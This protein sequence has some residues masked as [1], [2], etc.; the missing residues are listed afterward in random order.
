MGLDMYL[1]AKRYMSKHFDKDDVA[2]QA[3]IAEQFPELKGRADRWGDGSPVKEVSIEAA[4]WR[5]ANAIHKWFVDNVQDGEDNCAPYYV[6]RE[7]LE[8]LR[9]LCQQ[10]LDFRHLATDKLPPQQ[11]FFFGTA[12]VNDFYFQD[13]EDTIRMI[14]EALTLPPNWDFEYRASW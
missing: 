14:N 1:T 10:V 11:G 6:S 8:E 5:K 3:A 13:L 7:K 2:R 12:E 4:Y 9:A